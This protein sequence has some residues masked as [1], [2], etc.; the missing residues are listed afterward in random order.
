ME[1]LNLLVLSDLHGSEDA[2]ELLRSVEA[3]GSYDLV[4]VCGDFTTY[5]TAK[6]VRRFLSSARTKVLAVPGNCDTPEIVDALEDSGTSLHNRRVDFRRWPF[7]GFGGA[8]VTSQRMPFE[9]EEDEIEDS[10]RSV[11]ARGGVMVT[12]APA[13]GMN[14]RGFSGHH[15]G[16]KGIMRVAR[17]FGPVL[18]VSGHIHEDRGICESGGTVFVNP[19]PANKGFYANIELGES[20]RAVLMEHPQG[21]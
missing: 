11:A 12:H 3:S 20:V 1:T 2:L 19:G 15:S 4:L 17:E 8:P 9:V 6:Y 18:A 14:D 5:G 13:Y 10:L 7:F 21:K 16:S